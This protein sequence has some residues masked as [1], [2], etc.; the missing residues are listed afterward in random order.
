MN[1]FGATYATGIDWGTNAGATALANGDSIS[2]EMEVP[3]SGWSSSVTMANRSV[4]EY[5]SNTG[6]EGVTANTVYSNTA[7]LSYG[8]AGN[9]IP[10]IASTTVNATTD[11]LVRFQTPIL[12]TDTILVE[13][14]G[15]SANSWRIVGQSY[16]GMPSILKN[17]G[18]SYYGVGYYK[19][20]VST[21][22]YVAFGNKGARNLPTN[23]TAYAAS[24][25]AWS[26][27]STNKW[28]VR[29]VSGQG[30]VGFPVNTANLIGRTDGNTVPAGQPGELLT[31]KPSPFTGATTRA[32][33]ATL[34]L[35]PGVWV[36]SALFCNAVTNAAAGGTY[37]SAAISTTP[38]NSTAG[39][40]D[41]YD[42]V[43][44]A[45][46]AASGYGSVSIPSKYVNITVS[47]AYYLN[48]RT[49]HTA[50]SDMVCS[51]SALRIV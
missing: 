50:A 34:T 38:G 28:R 22:I 14:W 17:E 3:I 8:M 30:T 48:G 18:D 10:S 15:S 45:F 49:D 19:T 7:Y 43:D 13:V 46:N 27:F 5:A 33:I 40:T 47:T 51:M 36:M 11:Y 6:A 42:L 29:K 24:G 25:T 26:A 39:C 16:N 9:T 2:V 31:H 1:G 12:D 44:G 35:T 41:G 32:Q 4:E 37:L 21:D 20:A 23:G